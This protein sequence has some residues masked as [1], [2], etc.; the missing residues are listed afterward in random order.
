[1]ILYNSLSSR[2]RAVLDALWEAG[3][4]LSQRGILELIPKEILNNRASAYT[5]INSLLEKDLIEFAGITSGKRNFARMFK[6]KIHQY[7][8]LIRQLVPNGTYEEGVLKF[9]EILFSE[10]SGKELLHMLDFVEDLIK[11]RRQELKK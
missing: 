7:E 4:P 3:K 11:K 5:A 1:M 10:L 9:F 6:P 2:E 8:F